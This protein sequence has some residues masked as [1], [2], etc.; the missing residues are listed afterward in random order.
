MYRH[1]RHTF[2]PELWPSCLG[3]EMSAVA[4]SLLDRERWPLWP[5]TAMCVCETLCVGVY[6]MHVSLCLLLQGGGGEGGGRNYSEREREREMEKRAFGA[7][8]PAL[9]WFLRIPCRNCSVIS[10]TSHSFS[11]LGVKHMRAHTGPS[12]Q[13][14]RGPNMSRLIYLILWF[15]KNIM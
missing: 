3:C 6:C 7:P 13:H 11:W 4:E 14:T 8:C 12:P 1:T 5:Y 10:F 9:A 15:S 2:S